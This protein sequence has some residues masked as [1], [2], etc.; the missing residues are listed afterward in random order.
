[1]ASEANQDKRKKRDGRSCIRRVD[2]VR[3]LRLHQDRG[4][5]LI[6]AVL[7]LVGLTTLG[8]VGIEMASNEL[9]DTARIVS[10]SQAL[11][12]ADAGAEEARMR[13]DPAAGADYLGVGGAG[14]TM[15]TAS[16]YSIGWRACVGDWT[17]PDAAAHGCTVTTTTPSLQ[18]DVPFSIAA[19]Q[20]ATRSGVIQCYNPGAVPPLYDATAGAC[21]GSDS[22][23]E[24]ITAKA[25]SGNTTRTV[26]A[27]FVPIN[28]TPF[29]QGIKGR[30]SVS[31]NSNAC[32]DSYNSNVAAYPVPAD[33]NDAV[34]CLAG[35]NQG[36]VGTDSTAN[37]AVF[38]DSNAQING[39]ATVGVGGDPSAGVSLFSNSQ[40]TGGTSIAAE[41]PS[42]PIPEIPAS[43]NCNQ[44]LN[45]DSTTQSIGTAC[46]SS[47]WI[48]D[49][50]VST[51]GDVTIYVTG[52]VEI[53]GDAIVNT[54]A[55]S[56]N[57]T[58]IV[59]GTDP[60]TIDGGGARI[61]WVHLRAELNCRPRFEC[62]FLW[63][64]GWQ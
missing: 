20:H 32:T 9:Q 53:Y 42:Y 17:S 7:F 10:R 61:H 55:N 31:L 21:L 14:L 30:Q 25:S 33:S 48:K 29:S 11:Y 54:T 40:V 23:A 8:L 56:T 59:T 34:K 12:Q 38:L 6:A 4:V 27:Q 15:E 52:Q 60:V 5:V 3:A 49:S 41:T 63:R 57:L 13:F 51:V 43:L 44:F 35:G 26:V 24:Q 1:M 16:P 19:I 39:G 46:Y 18:I 22:P 58:I 2:G 50:N 36:S 47:L 37:G 64:A 45:L 28:L 62:R